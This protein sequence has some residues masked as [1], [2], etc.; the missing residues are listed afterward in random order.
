MEITIQE[1]NGL[2]KDSY[3][4]IDI[5]SDI[6]ISHGA[7]PGAIHAEVADIAKDERIDLHKKLILGNHVAFFK[8]ILGDFTAGKSCYGVG[9]GRLECAGAG[10]NVLNVPACDRKGVV[11]LGILHT[12]VSAEKAEL[13]TGKGGNCHKHD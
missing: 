3:Q 1:L 13:I 7:I 2:E 11:G 4:I 10:E 8:I 6:E 5:R 12:A 9:I